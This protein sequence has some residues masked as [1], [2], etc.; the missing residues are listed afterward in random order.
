METVR[1]SLKTFFRASDLEIH[2][3]LG[4]DALPVA[5]QNLLHVKWVR[6]LKGFRE[7][8]RLNSL[9]TPPGSTK[10]NHLNYTCEQLGIY[11]SESRL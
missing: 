3:T 4:S 5:L 11:F 7:G 6:T 10:N 9:Y 1:K 2:K 8:F